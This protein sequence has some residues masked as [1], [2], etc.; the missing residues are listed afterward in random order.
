MKLCTLNTQQRSDLASFVKLLR[1]GKSHLL[2]KKVPVR[3]YGDIA[4]ALGLSVNQVQHL[5]RFVSKCSVRTKITRQRRK[6][7]DAQKRYLL[8]A[9]TLKRWAGFTIKDRTVIFETKYPTKKLAVT[10][11][12]RFYLQNDV[13]LKVVRQEKRMPL[14]TWRTFNDQR[15]EQIQKLREVRAEGRKIIY[16]DEICF[17]KRSFMGKTWSNRYSNVRVDQA[18]LYQGYRATCAT[19]SVEEGVELLVT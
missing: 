1:F 18:Q 11:L 13:K 6:L 3:A 4:S 8:D 7:T 9:D 10:S 14:S 16:L 5:C 17:T 12:R 2:K 19:V 15:L